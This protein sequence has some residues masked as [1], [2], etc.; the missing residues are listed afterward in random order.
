VPTVVGVDVAE[1]RKGL[2][3]VALDSRRVVIAS[4]GR[5]TLDQTASIILDE[6][7]PDV[8]CIDSPSGWSH[9]GKSRRSEIELRKLG[10]TAFS[11]PSDPGDHPFYRW[12]RV[13]FSLYEALSPMYGLGNGSV[14]LQ[15]A[16]EVFPEATAVLLA[17]RLRNST[18]S[19]REFRGNVL[20]S[21]GIDVYRLPTVDRIDA[22]LA[23]V[24]G[25]L[26]LEGE[27]SYL[28]DPSEG[29]I[30]IPVSEP[31]ATRLLRE[32]STTSRA[33]SPRVLMASSTADPAPEAK[34][35]GHCLCG[36]GAPVRRRFLPGHDAKLRSAL[37]K[38]EAAGDISASQRLVDLGWR[39]GP[40]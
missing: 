14:L 26:A 22:A 3:L 37:Y 32:R 25:I 1:E 8:V 16:V 35:S 27:A 19:K 23:A 4:A 33:A 39:S 31:P 28:G 6:I 36:C 38:A 9:S 40:P 11:T 12:M 34:A 13:G 20:E 15:T 5:L 17:G 10:I 24:T 21:Q 2:D 29:T 30:L 18:E 7:R